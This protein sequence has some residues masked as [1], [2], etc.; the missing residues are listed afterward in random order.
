MDAPHKDHLYSCL[1][2][3]DLMETLMHEVVRDA[4]EW[5]DEVKASERKE[6]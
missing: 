4:Q 1:S 2:P 5:I 6:K 3:D